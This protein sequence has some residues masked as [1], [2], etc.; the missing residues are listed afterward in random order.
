MAHCYNLT[1]STALAQGVNQV[2]GQTSGPR[3]HW[4]S[5]S[6][7]I[8]WLTQEIEPVI[9]ARLT[10]WLTLEYSRTMRTFEQDDA[11]VFRTH[12][13]GG[14]LPGVG[15]NDLS[16]YD[17]VPDTYTNIDRLK[18]FA[19]FG[20]YTDAYLLGYTGDNGNYFRH[21]HRYFSGADARFTNR[22]IEGLELTAY[23][24]VY[25]T[26][27]TTP[28]ETLNTQFGSNVW[29]EPT[30]PDSEPINRDYSAMGAT[31]RWRPFHAEYGTLRSRMGIIGGYEYAQI[32]RQN[33]AYEL[34][35]LDPTATPPIGAGDLIDI[36]FYQ[37]DSHIN[38]FFVGVTES[39]TDSIATN[40]KYTYIDT[41][42][43][44][45][46]VT[47]GTKVVEDPANPAG[48][49]INTS[50]PTHVDRV[51]IG[52]T[53]QPLDNFLFNATAYIENTYH[54]SP[55]AHFEEDSY[56][57]MLSAWY[58]PTC[59]LSLSA[60]FAQ[61]TNWIDQDI[62]LGS[63]GRY[64]ASGPNVNQWEETPGFTAP[65]RYGG[66]SD[67]VNLGSTYA[68]TQRLS[69]TGC[70]EY[71]RA[72]DSYATPPGPPTSGPLAVE[73]P[74]AAGGGVIDVTPYTQLSDAS[75][76][77]V[78]TYRLSAGFDYCVR[79]GVTTFFRYNYYDYGDLA[80]L[81]NAGEAHMFLAG[82]SANY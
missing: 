56:P 31:S 69:L 11:M 6:Q 48:D 75:R 51:E 19:R 20:E 40:L 1:G 13:G 64:G 72:R 18:L 43:P 42:Y 17:V 67:V 44:L 60:G 15:A 77:E 2:P 36:T 70:F 53:W 49:A 35:L 79:N 46:G 58:A 54:R 41:H 33:A 59:K 45:F 32:S 21:T 80:M 3:C 65:W 24:K 61:L 4:L 7:H 14:G 55:Y 66:K 29:G 34:E 47:E 12:N 62:T 57:W 5:Q 39:W 37:P 8:D 78:E 27:T 22:S 26:H 16:P 28:T 30:L 52:G 10:D 81:Y 38:K 74:P 50:L 73:N 9:E 71:V 82:L 76:V 25:T 68:L 63:Q 23:G